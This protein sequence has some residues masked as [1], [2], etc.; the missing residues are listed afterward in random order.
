MSISLNTESLVTSRHFVAQA[1]KMLWQ[2]KKVFL[3]LAILPI[4][5]KVFSV[6]RAITPSF[7]PGYDVITINELELSLFSVLINFLELAL[8]ST[9]FSIAWFRYLLDPNYT[10]SF[11][12][13]FAFD[14]RFFK[15]NI[16]SLIAWLL[17]LA[18]I[19]L[20]GMIFFLI[21]LGCLNLISQPSALTIMVCLS[22]GMLVG[23][24]IALY[25]IFPIS[26]VF[27]AL[28]LNKTTDIVEIPFQASPYRKHFF[29]S[30]T[31]MLLLAF[32]IIF[33]AV[34]PF[35]KG[36]STALETANLGL[37]IL[38]YPLEA[39]VFNLLALYYKKYLADQSSVVSID[40]TETYC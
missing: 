22:C 37:A 23:L 34:L 17:Y 15:F 3:A 13:Y 9:F 36:S 30:M 21:A 18:G 33:A 12:S 5:L 8:A 2:N 11:K 1:C 32:V 4:F 35:S 39:F 6:F 40:T 7:N 19:A 10:P 27:P 29:L 16:Y 26:L 20:L 25:Y 31:L 28:A 14:K 38:V 24:G